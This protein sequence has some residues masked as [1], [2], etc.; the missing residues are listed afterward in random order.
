LIFGVGWVWWGDDVVSV[1]W[2]E[3]AVLLEGALGAGVWG[4]FGGGGFEWVVVGG[5]FG[6]GEFA[7]G[8]GGAAGEGGCWGGGG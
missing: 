4:V 7:E 5:G 3:F 2:P 8:G 6:A 1:C